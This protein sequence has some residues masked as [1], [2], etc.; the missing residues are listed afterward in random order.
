MMTK[1]FFFHQSTLEEPDP[2]QFK[3]QKMLFQPL[4]SNCIQGS[5][6]EPQTPNFEPRHTM[7]NSGKFHPK[8]LA[9]HLTLDSTNLI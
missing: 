8:I 9:R 5:Y 4:N 7:I 1:P 2:L 3:S 6:F